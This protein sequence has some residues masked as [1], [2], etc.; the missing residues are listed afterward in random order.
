MP[1]NPTNLST[2]G[3][4]ASFHQA[5]ENAPAI[6]SNHAMMINSTSASEALVFP[7]FIPAPREF[8]GSRQFQDARDFTYTVANKEYELSMVINRKAWEDDQTGLINTRLSEMGEVWATWKDSLFTTLLANGNVSGNNGFDGVTFHSDDHSAGTTGL[9]TDNNLSLT[10]ATGTV[11][12]VAEFQ[13]AL[14][15]TRQAFQGFTDD[16]GRPY[17]AQALANL[18]VI[19]HPTQAKAVYEAVYQTAFT[20]GSGATN[21]W[22][23]QALQGIDVNLYQASG[24]SDEL[25]FSALGSVR[26]PFIYQERTALEVVI[27][28]DADNVAAFNGVQVLTRQRYV[29]TYGDP[30]RSILMT[31]T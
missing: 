29:L 2:K 13:T 26:K 8:L 14:D 25:Y 7:G 4:L 9:T 20:G 24:D 15:N 31:A 12:T 30:R 6:W 10:A 27:L 17:N 28:A 16:T 5:M 3:A 1:W 19:I 21:E 22:G 18:R 23:N 11:F